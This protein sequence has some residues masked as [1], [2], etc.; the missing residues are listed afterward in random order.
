MPPLTPQQVVSLA[1]PF[2]A[3]L[4]GCPP[5]IPAGGLVNPIDVLNFAMAL[6]YLEAAFYNINVPRF[7]HLLE[8]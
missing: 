8:L 6:E 3:D 5:L 1:S 2:I 4:N 7:E